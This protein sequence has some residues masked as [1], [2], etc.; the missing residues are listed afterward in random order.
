MHTPSNIGLTSLIA[1]QHPRNDTTIITAPAP[2]A[3]FEA[4]MKSYFEKN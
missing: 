1:P 3:M 4:V 2:M